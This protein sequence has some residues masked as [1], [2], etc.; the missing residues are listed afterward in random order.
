MVA[1]MKKHTAEAGEGLS[2]KTEEPQLA[3]G[4]PEAELAGGTDRA[5]EL[6]VKLEEAEKKAA[7]NYDK[8]VRT[9]A[10]LDNYRKRAAR[11][12]ADAIQYGNENLLRD[13]LPLVDGM[14]R[15]LEHACN[16]E[17]FEAF[18][19]GLKL[20]QGQL[21]GCLQKHGVEMIDTAGKDFD[22]HVHE[23]MM[24]VESAEHED[25]QVV[26]EFERGYLLNGRLLR[27]A[28]VSVCKRPSRGG[29]R[30]NNCEEVKNH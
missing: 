3:V 8:Y 21:L 17:D 7:D 6:M 12:K 11:E 13:I 14:D 29:E 27:P 18:R 30:E 25:S 10:E 24:Q 20:L 5:E 16:S 22:P 4:G 19:K 2:K 15:A 23:A 26:G 28:K 1:K 9:V